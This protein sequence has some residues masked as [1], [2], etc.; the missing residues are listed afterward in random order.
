[1]SELDRA[2]NRQVA[3][4]RR[5]CKEAETELQALDDPARRAPFIDHLEAEQLS[6]FE[7]AVPA[8]WV[9]STS[10]GTPAM[11]PPRRRAT[12]RHR[13]RPARHNGPARKVRSAR[14]KLR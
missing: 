9:T 7:P 1:M 11:I 3:A 13:V 12:G 6:G 8:A 5:W 14:R 10:P 2:L 4:L